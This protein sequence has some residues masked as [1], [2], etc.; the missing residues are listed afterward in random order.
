MTTNFNKK[1]KINLKEIVFSREER[2]SFCDIFIYKPVNIEEQN[3]GDLYVIGEVV[4]FSDNSSYL[5]NLL[6]SIGKK[7]FY[8]NPKKTTTESLEAS[9]HKINTD[10]SKIAEQGKIDWI[11]NL[12]MTYCAY[13]NGKIYLSQTGDIRTILIRENKITDIGKEIVNQGET[14]AL[15]TFINIANGEL[16][17]GD[18]VLFAT[19]E[20]FNLF[21]IKKLKQ[22]ASSLSFEE[23]TKV[24]QESIEKN[25]DIKTI[26]LLFMKIEDKNEEKFPQIELESQ[27][28]NFNNNEFRKEIE[29]E[30]VSTFPEI[31]EE[32]KS[33]I[34]LDDFINKQEV[35]EI[36]KKE[37]KI[38]DEDEDEDEEKFSLE[39]I[40]SK[41][42]NKNRILDKNKKEFSLFQKKPQER[43]VDFIE[44]LDEKQKNKTNDFKKR[45]KYFFAISKSRIFFPILK[46]VKNIIITL[47]NTIFKQR[48]SEDNFPLKEKPENKRKFIFVSFAF[49]ILLLTG[50]L[51]FKNYQENENEKF[52][53][54]ANLINQAENKINQAE[55]DAI[56]NLPEARKSLIEA[57]ELIN[58]RNLSLD[59]KEN[60]QELFE[61]SND[62]SKKIAEQSNKIN[63][64]KRI[65]NPILVF[66][67][68]KTKE[69]KNP[70]KIFREN[71][72][73]YVFDSEN[74]I[75][76]NINFTSKDLNDFEIKSTNSENFNDYST[77]IEKTGE[78]IF[79]TEKLEEINIFNIKK[80]NLSK[81][82][83]NF[84]ENTSQIKDIGSYSN[85]V[86][87]LDSNANQI[88]KY[89]K[90][91][92]GFDDG[93]NWL[94]TDN[95]IE[96]AVSMTIDGSIYLLKTDGTIDKFR[97]GDKIAEFEIEIPSDSISDS[98]K[99]YT[100][101]GFKYLYITDKVKNRIIIFEK[102][103]GKLVQQYISNSFND[104]KN[105]VIDDTEN[106]MYILNGNKI[107]VIE[108]KKEE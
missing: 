29:N 55:I 70:T 24:I 105:I 31:K 95:N 40:I 108:I 48:D 8:A 42:E 85:F 46:T 107:F 53:L 36:A 1:I 80:E 65:E 100:K 84:P 43:T 2:K 91:T 13:K 101:A 98:A 5:I 61:K 9:L 14:H 72:N 54:Y 93:K 26:G 60:Y 81:V 20:F 49:I 52:N 103:S 51:I 30:K 69:I 19:S 10:L 66:D 16:E 35:Y 94:K 7:E 64:I 56:S 25:E 82:E 102:A 39:D 50:G 87:F 59:K 57:Q 21:S 34:K 22:L 86:Y 11:G 12:N 15:K 47:K 88:Y 104:L 96:K 78:L 41:Y 74:K 58:S 4:D 17:I 76:K 23:L 97:T 32:K 67:F 33:E 73:Y 44:E 99:I 75:L 18:L 90:L 106:K 68:S 63:F 37:D 62:I 3:L 27:K 28:T 77:L 71:K 92:N 89:R 6:A 45:L 38:K 79:T 83:I